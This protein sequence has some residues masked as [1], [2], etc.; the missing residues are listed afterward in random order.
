MSSIWRT[1]RIINSFT[2]QGGG[3]LLFKL[4]PA[5]KLDLNTNLHFMNLFANTLLLV[6]WWSILVEY[7]GRLPKQSL[8]LNNMSAS[9]QTCLFSIFKNIFLIYFQRG[10]LGNKRRRKAKY[11]RM[12]SVAFHTPPTGG[13]ACSPST[14]PDWES[15]QQPFGPKAGAQLTEPHQQGYLVM[16]LYA[17][18]F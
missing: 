15:N 13:L 5:V 2:P 16:F 3:I 12:R 18:Q 17:Q 6:Y 9:T 10:G 1:L 11:E 14:C 7:T 8:N 4:K